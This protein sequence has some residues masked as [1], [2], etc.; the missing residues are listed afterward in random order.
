MLDKNTS[1]GMEAATRLFNVMAI[2]MTV[3]DLTFVAP[4]SNSIDRK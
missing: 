3:V 4:G 2:S 1:M